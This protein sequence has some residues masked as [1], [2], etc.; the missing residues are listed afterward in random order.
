MEHID[1]QPPK[2]DLYMPFYAAINL[3]LHL[4]F[5]RQLV[6][7]ENI[8]SE[9]AVY[10]INHLRFEDSILVAGAYTQHTHK[11]MRFGAKKEYFDGEGIPLAGDMR[12]GKT[13]K[14]F[15]EHGRMI[16]VD[17]HNGRR[18]LADLNYYSH[19]YLANGDAIALHPEGTRSEDGRLN[20]FKSGAARVAIANAVPIVPVGL[21][22][23]D[24][25]KL[26]RT[27][28]S[29]HFGEPVGPEEYHYL[30]IKQR[31]ELISDVLER[32][33]AAM[34]G[35]ERTHEFA[36]IKRLIKPASDEEAL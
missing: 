6:G 11:P 29:I 17:R 8:P 30:P 20:K 5:S 28:V 21:V 15:M 27:Q 14:F 23:G 26:N 35:Q 25:D 7:E 2:K 32:R 34:T 9:P 12:L 24:K 10:A 31:S 3:G 19:L 4:K 36:V 16:P 22:Y 1:R 18:S 13:V 33:V